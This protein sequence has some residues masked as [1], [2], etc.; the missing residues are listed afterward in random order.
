M[1][2]T[3]DVGR[4]RKMLKYDCGEGV[5]T[6]LERP[7]ETFSPSATRT[8]DHVAAL[9]N[10]R[11]AGKPALCTKHP[12][13][14]LQGRVDGRNFLAS[15]VAW[16]LY[17]GEWPEQFIDHINGCRSDDRIANLRQV[18][19]IGNGRNQKTN[20]LNTSG[21]MGVRKRRS[22]WQARI[23]V[24]GKD[25]NLGYFDTYEEAVAVRKE[26]E[27]QYGFHDNH[28]RK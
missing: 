4:L 16:A 20:K 6:W 24:R 26:A 17:H 22:R 18:D 13:G 14:Y 11:H 25:V 28:G 5:L 12:N 7:V 1:N 21:C 10:A 19:K 8:A 27:R 9:W 15:R 2:N 23:G 3:I